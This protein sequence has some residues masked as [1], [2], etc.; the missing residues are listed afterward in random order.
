MSRTL[1]GAESAP[2]PASLRAAHRLLRK[3]LGNSDDLRFLRFT[4]RTGGRPG[5]LIYVNGLC[6]TQILH[7]HVLKPLMQTAL[8][9][10]EPQRL[11]DWGRS[12]ISVA[13]QN[14]SHSLHRVRDEIFRGKAAL[15]IDGCEGTLLLGSQGW[16]ERPVQSPPT[17]STL[18]GPRDGFVENITSNLALIRRRLN[19]PTLRVVS[20]TVGVRSK[21]KVALVYL[22][23]L[24]QPRL[25]REITARIEAVAYDGILDAHQLR[26][27]IS[28][29]KYSPFPKMESTE[30]PDR[31]A[32][33]LLA[34]KVV[35]LVDNSPFVL[36]APSTLI[37][38]LWA[39]DDYYSSPAVT[40]L[41]RLVRVIGWVATVSLSPLYIATQMYNPDLLRSD[42]VLFLSFERGGVPLTAALEILFLETMMEMI[43]EAT[44]R[45][46]SKIGSAATVVG[47]LIV[48]QAA[49][50]AGLLSGVVVIVVAISAISS[51]TL[52]NQELAQ[53]WRAVKWGLIA[54]ASIFGLYGMFAAALVLISWLNS[55][56]SFGVPYLSPVAPLIPADLQR[57][58]IV[59]RPWDLLRRRSL[60]YRPLD[61]DRSGHVKKNRSGRGEP[62]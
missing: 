42:L 17:E 9:G 62:Q 44:I 15:L 16:E 48:G 10:E 60:T 56:D 13:D 39:P 6:N 26:E 21:T 11:V 38:S 8:P 14:L 1:S 25:V 5:L 57:D 54:A 7:A 46:P 35:V 52:P 49:V 53:I 29:Q 45:L 18:R 24:A 51:F 23:N 59:R 28:Q 58:S 4:L 55:Q 32:A 36:A 40:I 30:R 41:V 47:G 22:G 31:I 43:H 61:P 33:A 20:F 50:Q 34:G 37:D 19:D 12:L 27:L 2:I 3:A